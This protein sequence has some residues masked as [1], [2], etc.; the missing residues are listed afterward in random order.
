MIVV[1]YGSIFIYYPYTKEKFK[2]KHLTQYSGKDYTLEVIQALATQELEVVALLY[3][4]D[5][6]M[7]YSLNDVLLELEDNQY[8]SD[9]YNYLDSYH[10]YTTCEESIYDF[11]DYKGTK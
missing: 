2:S 10:T 7:L 4:D 6:T 1:R 9:T 8:I 5:N 11:E 3:Y